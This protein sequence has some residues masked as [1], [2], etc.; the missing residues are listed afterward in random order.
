MPHPPHPPPSDLLTPIYVKSDSSGDFP[1]YDDPVYY[2][3]ARDGLFI[4]R[5]TAN[6]AA[7]FQ[8]IVPAPR[9]PAELA[10]QSPGLVLDYP[11]L[12]GGRSPGS[13]GS[14]G[15]SPAGTRP[16]PWCCWRSTIAA[17]TST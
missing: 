8:S 17:S 9:P 10:A 13:W 3:L 15:G 1:A 16:K 6:G 7:R 5:N 14:S 11:K 12:S 4:G 2:V